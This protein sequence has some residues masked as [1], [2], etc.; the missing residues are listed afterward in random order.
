[1]S[2]F[3][4]VNCKIPN[5]VVLRLFDKV[6]GPFGTISYLPGESF[7]LNGGENLVPSEFFSKWLEVNSDTQFVQDNFI[8]RIA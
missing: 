4:K 1:M 2:E 3:T 8:E 6:E 5:G 7:T